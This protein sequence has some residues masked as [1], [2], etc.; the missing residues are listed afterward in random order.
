MTFNGE[1]HAGTRSSYLANGL[2]HGTAYLFRVQTK[3]YNG[4]EFSGRL[5]VTLTTECSAEG[6]CAQAITHPP[7]T[8]FGDGIYLM[9]LEIGSGVYEIDEDADQAQCEWERLANLDGSD[10]QEIEV[11]GYQSGLSVAL[12]SADHAFFTFNC[13][14]WTILQE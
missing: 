1:T 11:G 10:G 9:G 2:Q 8:S 13:G 6:A 5:S 14:T 4:Q 7:Y 12:T 3:S